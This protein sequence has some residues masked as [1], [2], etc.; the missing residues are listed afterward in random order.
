MG[1]NS[2]SRPKDILQDQD[3][4]ELKAAP[5]V[6][7]F[8][9]K[10]DVADVADYLDTKVDNTTIEMDGS[11]K[12]HMKGGPFASSVHN[13]VAS[14]VTD[15]DTEVS[16][17]A[18]VSD[19][20]TKKHVQGTDQGLD[21]GGAN[22]IT[23][24]SARDLL[25]KSINAE[26]MV[27]P[28]RSDRAGITYQTFAAAATYIE[29]LGAGIYKINLAPGDHP[30]SASYTFTISNQFIL[31][32]GHQGWTKNT[33]DN[34]ITYLRGTIG[35]SNASTK[36]A[37]S[38]LQCNKVLSTNCDSIIL[39]DVKGVSG[40]PTIQVDAGYVCGNNVTFVCIGVAP[41]FRACKING[42]TVDLRNVT[43]GNTSGNSNTYNIEITGGELTLWNTNSLNK[44]LVIS[45]G[46]LNV[47]PGCQDFAITNTGG[48]VNYLPQFGGTPTKADHLVNKTYADVLKN[49]GDAKGDLI[50]FSADNTPVRVG[51]VGADG[52]VLTADAGSTGGVKWASAG[53]SSGWLGGSERT[54]DL[55]V[56]QNTNLEVGSWTNITSALLAGTPTVLFPGVAANNC[57]YIGGDSVFSTIKSVA[58][59]AMTIGTGVLAYEYWNGATWT[60]T[61]FM[62]TSFDVNHTNYQNNLW[63]NAQIDMIRH[64]SL[65]S[66]WATKMLNSITKYWIRI[67]ITTAITTSPTLSGIALVDD[68]VYIH[69]DGIREYFGIARPRMMVLDVMTAPGYSYLN[70]AAPGTSSIC[71][72][73]GQALPA[74]GN[75]DVVVQN[76]NNSLA[77]GSND[78]VAWVMRWCPEYD[79]SYGVD[80]GLSWSPGNT[81]LGNIQIFRD[82]TKVTDGDVLTTASRNTYVQDNVIIAAPGVA[83]QR[84]SQYYFNTL[85]NTLTFGDSFIIAFSRDARIGNANDTYNG[86]MEID[87]PCMAIRKWREGGL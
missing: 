21:T 53:F 55:A 5:P 19:S 72:A 62:A 6:D 3:I 52:T 54:T 14:D 20:T 48:T 76:G 87:Q 33:S 74:G 83:R 30:T 8:K 84:S 56:L 41:P 78:A 2:F 13:H 44:G 16:N 29:S 22:A 67:S 47:G 77:D 63:G 12:L 15:F 37:I 26:V 65:T 34:A 43:F 11:K 86:S 51:P 75:V 61:P 57:I 82:V 71:Y 25:E 35:V 39:E 24:V 49:L 10:V 28:A 31:I 81:N 4:D 23:A 46:T 85:A 79:T 68:A 18:D 80:V 64:S 73:T 60:T 1:K 50:G 7:T 66:G 58:T 45:G 9:V 32:E 38:N 42:G 36:L 40:D 69:T 70:G 27:N 17:N 59:I